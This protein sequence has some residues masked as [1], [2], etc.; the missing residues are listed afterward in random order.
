MSPAIELILATTGLSLCLSYLWWVRWRVWI[1]RQDLFR[2]RDRLWDTA[3]AEG[4]FS[5]SSYRECRRDVNAMIRLAPVLSL[6]T[7]LKLFA[8]VDADPADQKP[9]APKAVREARQAVFMRVFQ[10][11]FLESLAGLVVTGLVILF[12]LKD[13]LFQSVLN[14]IERFVDSKGV[15]AFSQKFAYPYSKA[16]I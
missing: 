7:F 3:R 4:L 16:A 12:G 2:I 8:I 11:I 13:D 15:Q 1:F 10:F 14:R 9:I 6:F 5:D